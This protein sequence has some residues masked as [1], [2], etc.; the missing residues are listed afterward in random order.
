MSHFGFTSRSLY[1]EEGVSTIQSRQKKSSIF[2]RFCT[3]LAEFGGRCVRF[4][5]IPRTKKKWLLLLIKCI[6]LG[7]LLGIVILTILWFTL[8]NIDDPETMFPAQS[9]VVVDRNGIELYRLFSEQDRTYIRGEDISIF[10]KNATIAIEDERFLTRSACFDVIGYARAGLSQIF[11]TFFV[12]SGGSTL[13]QQFAGNALVGR[14]RSLLRKVRELL[15]ACELERK[16]DKNELIELY[17]NWIPYGQNAY[18]IEQA[19]KKY[20]SKSAKDLSIA[21]AAVLASL[22]QRPSY[23]N[24]YGNH[25]RTSVTE[26]VETRVTNRVIR[27]IHDIPDEAIKIGLLGQF[28]GSGSQKIYIGGRTDQVIEN[29]LKQKMISIEEKELALKE[30]LEMKFAA[31]RTNI[32]APHF[33]LRI[34]EKAKEILGVDETLLEQG[35]FKITTTLNWEIQQVAEKMMTQHK[36]DT[37]KRFG[38]ENGALVALS[39]QTREVLAYVGNFDFNDDE[40]QGKI[41]M[42]QSP[43]Q[44]GSSF[45][46]FTYLAAFENSLTPGS[47][48]Y[49]VPTKFGSDE[50][51]NFDGTFW[52]PIPV[53]KAL[54]GSRNIPAIKAFFL[55]GGEENLLSLV[56]RMGVQ[57]PSE[58]RDKYREQNS[59]FSYGWPLS[60]GA[61]ETPLI[62]MVQGYATIADGGMFTPLQD[63]LSITDKEGNILYQTKPTPPIQVVDSR[64]TAEVSSILSD[65][66]ARPDNE[67][68]KTILSV[69]GYDAAAKTGTSNKC[70]ERNK[71]G[72]CTL[73]RPEST[74]TIGFTPNLIAGVWVGNATSQSL[75]EKA[76]GLTTAAP[77]WHDFMVTA[78]TKIKNPVIAFTYPEGLSRPLLSRLSGKLASSC[79]PPHLRSADVMPTELVPTEEDPACKLLQIDKVTKL[80]ASDSCPKEATEESSFFIPQSELPERWPLWEKG[81][82]EWAL[83]QMEKWNASENHSGSILPLPV[84]PT[85]SCDITKTPGRL[86]K[87]TLK[88]LTPTEAEI[89]PYP[90]FI[91]S[92][93]LESASDIREVRVKIDGKPIRTFTE[94]PYIGSVRIPKTFKKDGMHKLEIS[95]TDTYYNTA[96]G[97]VSIYFE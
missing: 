43:R 40:H 97:S 56:K 16:Y 13:T 53:R 74:W 72:G 82:Q 44:P 88:I 81:V 12:R 45:K 7:G 14:E 62:E 39:P 15:L 54:A 90:A 27:S 87:P 20:F 5:F 89:V 93:K 34:E 64:Y 85:E 75:Y 67:Y 78:Q 36:D 59:E 95:V 11:P 19:A 66:S 24:P 52:G 17:L 94:Q 26:E 77:I 48:L 73:R 84:A 79:T 86:I 61:A 76:D 29:M 30:L 83:K 22:P 51:E 70:L 37:N 57:T 50:P 6:G 60:I 80:L 18:G 32:R 47:I 35:G 96:S 65:V 49:D 23:F 46:A 58:N 4:L 91:P 2:V 3:V 92:I 1:E 31:D 8:P 41:D 63:I 21:E 55:G 68:W 28:V 25:I 10:A 9:T 38:A 33:V 42:T 71:K 69:P